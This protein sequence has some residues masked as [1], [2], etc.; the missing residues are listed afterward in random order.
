MKVLV[1]FWPSLCHAMLRSPVSI[2]L[3]DRERARTGLWKFQYFSGVF[4]VT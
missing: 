1:Q 3:R 4:R 2:A